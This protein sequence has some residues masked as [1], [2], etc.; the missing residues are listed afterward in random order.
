MGEDGGV[1]G[2]DYDPNGDPQADPRE[3]RRIRYEYR[4]LIAETQKNRH[5]FIRPDSTGLH[6][7]LD[8]AEKLFG[9]VR[10]TRE[11]VYDSHFLVLASNLGSQQA[12]QLQ[13]HLVTFNHDTF[14]QKLIT[15][16][17]GRNIT[18]ISGQDEEEDDDEM[19][20]ARQR[21]PARLDW[22]KLGHKACVAF[23]RTPSIDFMFG[24]LSM[25]PPPQRTKQAR[26]R[27]R[28]R[29]D[30]SQKVTPNQLEKVEAEGEATTKEVDR[31]HK[32]LYEKTVSGEDVIPVCLFKFIINPHSFGKTVEN[33]FHLSFLVRDG[34]AE[35][36]LDEENGLPLVSYVEMSSE[37]EK[38]GKKQVVVNISLAQYK[39]I[40][41]TFNIT[42][43]MIPPRANVNR[44]NAASLTNH[45]NQDED[46]SDE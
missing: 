13:T 3:R 41:K 45:I 1:A 40:I 7:A 26:E 29:P 20:A 27:P 22:K 43:P 30:L 10:S 12:Q 19:S 34:R 33:L 5:D 31:L 39:E 2:D 6:K 23:H 37:E 25:E 16:M 14:V 8:K 36:S 15:F 35:I 21:P 44:E 42:R 28:D 32:I 46:D 38:T 11:A 18:E 24:P 17:G 4:E 9:G